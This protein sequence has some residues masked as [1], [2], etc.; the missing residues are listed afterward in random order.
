M[1]RRDAGVLQTATDAGGRPTL[2]AGLV[3]LERAYRLP[4]PAAFIIF[5]VGRSAGWLAHAVEQRATGALI[6]PRARYVV[7]DAVQ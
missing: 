5:A 6:R 7:T 2:D 4:R 1:S 3:L